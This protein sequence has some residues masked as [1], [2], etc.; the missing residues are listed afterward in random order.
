VVKH[1]LGLRKAND[2]F[3]TNRLKVVDLFNLPAFGFSIEASA[4][5]VVFGALAF[6]L[7]FSGDP[8]PDTNRFG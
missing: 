8:D 7:I 4:L 1:S 2:R 3:T 5:F 6:G